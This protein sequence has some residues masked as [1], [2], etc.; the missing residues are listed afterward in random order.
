MIQDE[1]R[2][3]RGALESM[4][5]LLREN[6]AKLNEFMSRPAPDLSAEGLAK[7]LNEQMSGL[8]VDDAELR[9]LCAS[10]PSQLSAGYAGHTVATHRKLVSDMLKGIVEEQCTSAVNKRLGGSSAFTLRQA[11]DCESLYKHTLLVQP[12]SEGM[13]PAELEVEVSACVMG[14]QQQVQDM[15]ARYEA[16]VKRLEAKLAL[17]LVPLERYEAEVAQRRSLEA[18]LKAEKAKNQ[19][20]EDQLAR[21]ASKNEE[22]APAQHQ[23]QPG[24]ASRTSG[25]GSRLS[26]NDTR[27]YF[28]GGRW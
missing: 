12:I 2:V 1:L 21:H 17:E 16:E 8:K 11:A 14:I 4:E 23:Q 28:L 22:P 9:G 5:A 26:S 24:S 13:P 10:H 25:T 6:M 7:L 27:D 18:E 3:L 19:T 20:L 15:K